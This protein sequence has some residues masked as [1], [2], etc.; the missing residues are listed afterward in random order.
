[1]NPSEQK[2]YATTLQKNATKKGNTNTKAYFA[3]GEHIIDSVK[4]TTFWKKGENLSKKKKIQRFEVQEHCQHLRQ[5]SKK[6]QRL[7]LTT[8]SLTTVLLYKE[9]VVL[10]QDLEITCKFLT[11][12]GMHNRNLYRIWLPFIA[13]LV[14]FSK[15]PKFF[16]RD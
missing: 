5:T 3:T 12:S 4:G 10:I 2:S 13:V 14:C 1:M 7:V 16:K 15:F 11:K 9:Q 6:S 8:R